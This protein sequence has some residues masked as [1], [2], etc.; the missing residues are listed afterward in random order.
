MC[1]KLR[2]KTPKQRHWRRFGVFTVNFEHISHLCSSVSIVNFEQVHADCGTYHRII[3]DYV[4]QWLGFETMIV[5][6]LPAFT[7]SMSTM[8]TQ[9]QGVK[10]F[11]N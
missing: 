3:N 1:S 11:R 9:E 5:D 6:S 10:Y 7:C 8:E 2:I 4:H